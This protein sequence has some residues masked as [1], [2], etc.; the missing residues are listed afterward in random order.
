MTEPEII[1]NHREELA[2]LLTEAVEVEHNLMCCYLYAAWS[3]K[4]GV[5]DGLTET[6]AAEVERWRRVILG[7]AIDEMA[8]MANANNLLSAIGSRPH[9]GRPNFPVSPGYHPADVVV[10]LRRF[11]RGTLDHFVFLE[12]P[13]GVDLPDGEGFEHAF[14]YHRSTHA[15]M[16]MPTSQEYATVAHL[17]RSIRAVASRC[18]DGVLE[19]AATLGHAIHI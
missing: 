18:G 12:R 5:A 14:R 11:D 15:T 7:V 6:Q 1:V 16:L 17:Y 10:Q 13:E 4:H 8:H 2:E 19:L 9:L 3:L